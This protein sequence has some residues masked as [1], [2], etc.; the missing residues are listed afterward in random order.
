[1]EQLEAFSSDLQSPISV[2][3][4]DNEQ[5]DTEGEHVNI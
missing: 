3:A 5:F 1:M 4:V 2:L